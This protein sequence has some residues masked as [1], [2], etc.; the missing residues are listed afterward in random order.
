MIRVCGVLVSGFVLL[1]EVM[2]CS[3]GMLKVNVLF[4]L[5]WVWLIMFLLLS[6]SGR[7]SFWIVK[8]CLMFFFFNVWIILLWILSLVN[9]D[10]VVC[11]IV[12]I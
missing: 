12:V 8:G 7:V 3:S 9:V 11:F 2:C 6:V 10:L 5:V 4:M 1:L